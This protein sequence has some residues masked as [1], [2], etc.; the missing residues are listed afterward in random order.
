MNKETFTSALNI[1]DFQTANDIL[2]KVGNSERYQCVTRQKDMLRYLI[3][4]L[5]A[6]NEL[7]LLTV[8]FP[9]VGLAKEVEESL[10]FKARNEIPSLGST[11]TSF[12]NICY[13]YFTYHGDYHTGTL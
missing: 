2:M 1:G 3:D 7:R 5:C 8:D 13:S 9:F 6:H 10:L 12:Y 4:E 11:K